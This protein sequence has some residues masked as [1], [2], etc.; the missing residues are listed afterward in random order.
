MKMTLDRGA[1]GPNNWHGIYKGFGGGYLS[2]RG[3]GR[4][5]GGSGRG[6]YI[7]RW[8]EEI[9][10]AE[11]DGWPREP[12]VGDGKAENQFW[13]CEHMLLVPKKTFQNVKKNLNKNFAC[14]CRYYMYALN[15]TFS[16]SNVK[17][18]NK[19][20]VK[21]WTESWCTWALVISFFK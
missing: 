19:Y 16:V 14:I 9:Q 1:R 13:T 21:K 6:S 10:G 5:S 20:L 3:R 7:R 12:E 18:I 2:W 15:F 17:N 8:S 4:T 11:V